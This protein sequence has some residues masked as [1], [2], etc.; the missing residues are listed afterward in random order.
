MA[1]RDESVV[2]LAA[3]GTVRYTT[4]ARGPNRPHPYP[5]VSQLAA[6]D[7]EHGR[8]AQGRFS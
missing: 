1:E 8:G 4:S 5:F 7:P 3:L 6:A 2:T